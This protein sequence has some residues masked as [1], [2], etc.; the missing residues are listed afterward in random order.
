VGRTIWDTANKAFPRAHYQ[1]TSKFS[2]QVYAARIGNRN[3]AFLADFQND[4]GLHV[5][6][7]TRAQDFNSCIENRGNGEINCPDVYLRR[8]G[9]Q[10]ATKYVHGLAAGNRHFVVKTGGSGTGLGIKIYEVTNPQQPQLV[11]QDFVGFPTHG[12][13]HGV[14]LWTHNGQHYLATRQSKG[15]QD[16]GK[17]FNVTSCLTTGCAGLQSLEVWRSPQPLKPYPESTYWLS[18]IFSRSGATPFIFFGNHDPCRQGE[19]DFQTEYLFD[20]SNPAAPR[21]ISPQS[22][23]MDPAPPP[24]GRAVDYWSWYYSDTIRGWSHFGPRVA[25]FNGPYL[26]RAAAT[27]FDVH[28]WTGAP[29]VA[30]FTWAPD[31]IYVG[32]P[33]T[34]T[35]TSTGG[36]PTSFLWT[37]QDGGP[38]TT[39]PVP[40]LNKPR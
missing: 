30:G 29:P 10:E 19:A 4:L 23:I 36:I 31:V 35:N 22:H 37:F 38:A 2:Y 33:V 8:I 6:D 16:V 18:T 27:I 24:L 28:K 25:K 13:S 12:D 17:I 26:Y 40:P 5:Y 1:D 39:A 3:Y 20:V 14:A 11:V 34:F 7:M 9:S 21:D 15:S 32:D